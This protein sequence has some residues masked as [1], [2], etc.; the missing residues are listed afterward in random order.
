MRRFA[1]HALLFLSL[2]FTFSAFPAEI[3]EYQS[4]RAALPDGRIV[5]VEGFGLTRDAFQ[6]HFRTGSFHFLAPVDGHTFGAVF[7][8]EGSYELVPANE[9]ERRHLGVVLGDPNVRALSDTFD[10][11]VLLF[12]DRTAFDI[13]SIG[14]MTTGPADPAA[15]HIYREYLERQRKDYEINLH[16]RILRDILDANPSSG[17]FLAPVDGHKYAPAL[18]AV[19]PLGIGNVTA[20]FASFG[21]EESALLSLDQNN[22]GFWYLASSRKGWPAGH[23]KPL[24]F[25]VDATDYVV[26]T[27][28]AS[29]TSITGDTTITLRTTRPGLRVLPL[30]I[31]PKL[32][33][34]QATATIGGKDVELGIVQED[35]EKGWFARI[36]TE[37][38]ADADAA[39]VFPE[40]LAEG[41][42]VKLN[43]RYEGSDVLRPVGLGSYSVRARSSWYPN[44]GTFADTASYELTFRFPARHDLVATGQLA[45]DTTE[46]GRRIMVWESEKPMRIAGFN[47]GRFEKI[48][49][50]DKEA[51]V[52]I[53]VYTERSFAKKA[54]DTMADAQNATRVGRVFFGTAPYSPISVTQQ[55]EWSFGQSWPSLIYLPGLALTAGVD[56]AMMGE[57]LGPRG[58]TDMNEFAKMVGWH[59]LA[60]QWWGHEVGWQSYR[61]QWLSEGFAEFTSALVL[62]LTE[63][64]GSSDRYWERRRQEIFDKRSGRPAEEA[65]PIT[66]GVRLST[67]WTP[68]AYSTIVYSKGAY[69]L[70]MLRML[71]RDPHA[72]NPDE[73]FARMLQD[74]VAT[75]NGKSPSTADFQKFVERAMT[76]QM[77]AGTGSMQYFFDQWVYGTDVPSLESKLTAEKQPDGM[78]RIHGTIT[79][80]EV[81]P[82]FRT[83]VPIYL[84]FGRDQRVKVGAA[85]LIGNQSGSVDSTLKLPEAPKRVAINLMHDVL[86]RN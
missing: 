24:Q 75:E 76:P 37:M 46:S 58:M 8:G 85:L 33:I 30:H 51:G 70:H 83:V 5:A 52:E 53:D 20:S 31:L 48:H 27:T 39:V 7:I 80:S 55:A 77:A 62:E 19:D 4:L 41:R 67:Q 18:I 57:H 16:L 63:G 3:P 71:M 43:I 17:V 73:A 6:F 47:Y 78:Y 34:G 69:V 65:G 81:S 59:E 35:F 26:D 60:H 61:D 56:R 42:E 21:G 22:G 49:R 79:Q 54:R 86:T 40:P 45:S 74:F 15:V 64:P 12:S 84:E 10:S 72:A 25:P 14:R 9:S 38:A 11:L 28:I 13:A 68:G 50:V 82:T 29:N 44:V 2:L 23:G 66:D 32:R 1:P 36:F